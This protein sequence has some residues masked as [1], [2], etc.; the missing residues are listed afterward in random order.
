MYAHEHVDVSGE[1][2]C[3]TCERWISIRLLPGS[4]KNANGMRRNRRGR[5]N[6]KGARGEQAAVNQSF[7]RAC[8]LESAL[9]L[10]FG[11]EVKASWGLYFAANQYWL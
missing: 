6:E 8:F 2:R 7:Q 3:C 11:V 1:K 9:D 10:R 5:M 4:A